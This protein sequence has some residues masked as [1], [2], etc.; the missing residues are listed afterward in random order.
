MVGQRALHIGYNIVAVVV[1]VVI[2]GVRRVYLFISFAK[3]GSVLVKLTCNFIGGN[4]GEF[5]GIPSFKSVQRLHHFTFQQL[6]FLFLITGLV[7][8]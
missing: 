7:E 8:G 2:G 3:R 1:V 5:S 4:D 6:Y